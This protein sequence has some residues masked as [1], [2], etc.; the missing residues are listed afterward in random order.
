M[1]LA[2]QQS[3][4]PLFLSRHWQIQK[5]ILFSLEIQSNWILSSALVFAT[6]LGLELNFIEYT[7]A[8]PP[9]NQLTG[10][11]KRHVFLLIYSFVAS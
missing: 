1:K 10:Y 9:Y 4:R 3:L 8:C 5:L 2:K 11:G 7:M 6:H